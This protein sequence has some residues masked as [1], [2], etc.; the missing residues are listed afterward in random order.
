MTSLI[1]LKVKPQPVSF[2]YIGRA[3]RHLGLLESKWGNPYVLKKEADRPRVLQ[4]YLDYILDRPE[5]LADL[6]EIDNQVLGCY[7]VPKWC[8]GNILMELRFLQLKGDL[9]VIN[10]KGQTASYDYLPEKS[11]LRF[12]HEQSIKS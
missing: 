5:M 12:L 2:Y 4:N 10:G 8:H 9:M 11:V 6:H 3:N 7:C 1:N